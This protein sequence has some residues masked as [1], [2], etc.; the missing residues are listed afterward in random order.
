MKDLLKKHWPLIGIG[1]LVMVVGLYLFEA[2]YEI[3]KSPLLTDVGTEEGLKLKDIHYIQ[4]D[5][6]DRMKWTLD[7]E[8]VKFSKDKE[9]LSFKQFRLRLKP[10]NKSSIELKGKRGDFD[11]N[12]GEINMYGDLRGYTENGYRIITQHILYQQIFCWQ[13]QLI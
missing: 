6:G 2:H 3:R 8:E 9:F 10:E 4:N 5:P 12:S 7:A 1:V 13:W 11:K